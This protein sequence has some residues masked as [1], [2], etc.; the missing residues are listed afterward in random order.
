MKIEWA[1]S[2]LD[3]VN[4]NLSS[5]YKWQVAYFLCKRQK[6]HLD[7]VQISLLHFYPL[8]VSKWANCCRET[9]QNGRGCEG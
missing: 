9:R 5:D 4:K 7:T 6:I 2:G 8:I 3:L 1:S